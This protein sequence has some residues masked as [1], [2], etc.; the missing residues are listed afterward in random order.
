MRITRVETFILHVPVTGDLIESAVHSVTHWG[1]VGT[2]LHADSGLAGYGYT[3]THAH[4]ATDRLITDCIKNTYGPLLEGEE[5]DDTQRLWR[6]LCYFPPSRWVG[7]AGI[8]HLALA[9]VDIALWDLK[10]KAAGVPLWKLLGGLRPDGIDAY[11]TDGTWLN[12]SKQQIVDNARRS[13]QEKG[14]IGVKM[15]V[16]KPD[17]YED[18]ERIEAVRQAI[19]PKAKLMV[20]CNGGW[21][22]TSAVSIAR[23][24]VDYDVCWLEEPLWHDDCA[25]HAALARSIRTPIALGEQLYSIDAFNMFIRAEAVHF[26]QPDVTR[27]GGITEWWQ[28]ADLALANRLPVVCHVGDMMQVHLHTSLAHPACPFLEYIPWTREAFEEPAT[29]RDG[30]FVVPEKPGAGT[31]I[32]KDSYQRFK[33]G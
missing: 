22:L 19:G 10:A 2:I 6:K 13:I 16:G 12:L 18:L 1:L 8:T 33:V 31:T 25:G 3:G 32:R 4:L 20:D 28:V 5:G 27:L 26:V 30:R 7:R 17:P 14:F 11:M 24:F 9:A 23:K 15:W 21:N 29:A